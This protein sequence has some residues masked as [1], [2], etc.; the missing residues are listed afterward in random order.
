MADGAGSTHRRWALRLLG[1]G[2]VGGGI[3]W[4]VAVAGF[5]AAR[6]PQSLAV[7]GSAGAVTILFFAAGQLVQVAFADSDTLSLMVATLVSYAV[8]VVGLA[9]FAIG[10][11]VWLPELDPVAMAITMIAVVG[12]WIGVEIWVFVHLRIPSFDPPQARME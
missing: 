6:G 10:A 11:G 9:V 7:V 3:T 5:L 1:G 8:R 12:G 4:V 2:L